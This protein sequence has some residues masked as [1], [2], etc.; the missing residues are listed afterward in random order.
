MNAR[1]RREIYVVHISKSKYEMVE[2]MLTKDHILR[3]FQ[4]MFLEEILGLPP[5]WDMNF[6]IDL[7]LGSTLVYKYPYQMS[8][9]CLNDL[10][11]HLSKLMEKKYI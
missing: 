11:M 1:K 3:E 9:P 2:N 7:V 10:E 8:I 4:D 5:R 6:I